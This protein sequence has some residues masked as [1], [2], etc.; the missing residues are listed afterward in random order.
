[1]AAIPHRNM[2]ELQ[3]WLAGH[4]EEVIDPDRRIVDAHHHLWW[5]PPEAYQFPEL[6]ADLESGHDVRETVF[7]QCAAMYRADGP[8]AMRPIGETDY[9][10]G[11]AAIGASGL[12]GDRRP[13][14][15]IVGFADLTL[16]DAVAP[17]LAAHVAAGGGRFRGVRHQAQWDA[18]LGALA[19]ATPPRYLLADADFRRGFG[20][21]AP[22]GLSFDA[23]VYFTQ[24]DE[25]AA[26]AAAFPG[27]MIILNHI[28]APLGIGPY[29]GRKAVFET[30]SQGMRALSRHPGV[31]VKLGGM[32]MEAYGFGFEAHERP[33]SSVEIADAWRPY[34][35]HCIEVFG[36]ERCMFESNFPVDQQSCSYR[37]LWNAFKRIAAGCSEAER[38]AL[39]RGTA[40]RVYRLERA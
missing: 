6:M 34:I 15:G 37:T 30:W 32:G 10:N 39:F 12:F 5:R 36:V 9:V 18:T 7:V 27:T 19:R 16:G 2:A 40:T 3:R 24:L 8:E 31:M 17:V 35:E 20:H 23:W 28:G 25:V 21:L 11:I 1:L 26:L 14:S 29:A 33:A 4:V 22:L 13:C 38:D